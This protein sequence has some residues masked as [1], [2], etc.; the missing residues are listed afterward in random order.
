[1]NSVGSFTLCLVVFVGGLLL[2]AELRSHSVNRYYGFT[3]KIKQCEAHLPR[4]QSCEVV[5]T[6]KIKDIKEH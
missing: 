2:G 4:N 3:D 5:V 6:A 1:V